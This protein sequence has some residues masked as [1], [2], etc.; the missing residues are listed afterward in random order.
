MPDENYAAFN[1]AAERWTKMGFVVANP[2]NR[3]GG[4]RDVDRKTYMRHDIAELLQCDGIVMLEG[5]EFSDGALLEQ[6][7]AAQIG[8]VVQ[9]DKELTHA[10]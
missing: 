6:T 1:A 10:D 3:F 9:F 8:L 2:A 4:R 5:W 7:I